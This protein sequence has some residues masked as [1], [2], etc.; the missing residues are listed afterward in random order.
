MT[1]GSTPASP[2]VSPEDRRQHLDFIQAI[3]TRMSSASTTSKSWLMP[4]VTATYGYALTAHADS[5][6]LLGIAAV[7]LFAYLDANYLRQEQRFRRLYK[8]VAEGSNDIAAFSLQPDDV[9]NPASARSAEDWA[10]WMPRWVNRL[11]PGPSVWFSWAVGPFYVALVVVGIV[12]AVRV[13]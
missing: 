5:V 10:K 1:Q 3:I 8:A 4:V 13:R 7:L 11:L 9:P 2:L 6:A 12:I